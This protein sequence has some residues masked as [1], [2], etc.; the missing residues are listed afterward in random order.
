MILN[1]TYLLD[2]AQV[3][4]FKEAATEL[5]QRHAHVRVEVG[6]PWPPY[7]FASLEAS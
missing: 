4:G 7:S 2:D 6:G 5:G 3:E 1:G